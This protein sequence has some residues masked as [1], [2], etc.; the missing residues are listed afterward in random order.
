VAVQAVDA[1]WYRR[2]AEVM[3]L[4]VVQG[5]GEGGGGGDDQ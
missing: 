3:E 1:M 5:A 4:R 2:R